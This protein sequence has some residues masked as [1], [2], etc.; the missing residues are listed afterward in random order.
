MRHLQLE[1]CKI[2]NVIFHEFDSGRK[3]GFLQPDNSFCKVLDNRRGIPPLSVVYLLVVDRFGF[4]LEPVGFPVRFAL[5]CFEEEVPF[6]IDPF[7]GGTL[8][9]RGDVETFLWENKTTPWILFSAYAGRRDHLPKL[10]K[11]RASVPTC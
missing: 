4:Q 5:G 6:Y 7:S 3:G 11:P 9:S 10:P 1:V 8:L 2:L